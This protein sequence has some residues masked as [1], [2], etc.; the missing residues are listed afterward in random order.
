MAVQ[1]A[2]AS[3]ASEVL[4]PQILPM[5]PVKVKA[6]SNDPTMKVKP[7]G[8][9]GFEI[10]G[11]ASNLG[12][13]LMASTLDVTVDGK[14]VSVPLSANMTPNEAFLALKKKMPKGYQAKIVKAER[15]ER[16]PGGAVT[17]RIFH[18]HNEPRPAKQIS[19]IPTVLETKNASASVDATISLY[20]VLPK[21]RPGARQVPGR[22]ISGYVQVIGSGKADRTPK[23]KV[24][25]IKVYEQGTDK[26][27]EKFGSDL[28]ATEETRWGQR[29]LSFN[30]GLRNLTDATNQYTFV[31]TTEVDGAKA[32]QVRSKY[33][34]VRQR[35]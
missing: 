15:A 2:S 12:I 3:R 26:L 34:P 20:R 31:V 24:T 19:K 4:S 27:V 32:E 7:V 25:G 29:T 16:H 33:V 21:T 14:K 13:R 9:D 28:R 17:V 10:R 35:S 8:V 1:G 23:L 18:K 6:T 5:P 11:T 30:L 22:Q